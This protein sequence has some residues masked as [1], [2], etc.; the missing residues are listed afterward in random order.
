MSVLYCI[1]VQ[2]FPLS[3]FQPVVLN[4][5]NRRRHKDNQVLPDHITQ[6]VNKV[7]YHFLEQAKTLRMFYKELEQIHKGCVDWMDPIPGGPSHLTG[8]VP[9]AGIGCALRTHGS[10]NALEGS[11]KQRITPNERKWF[12]ILHIVCMYC[13]VQSLFTLKNDISKYT[14]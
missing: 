13:S 4:R 3:Y 14:V 8:E 9:T 11:F 10:L 1:S 12:H 5:V 6:A 2:T 7:Q